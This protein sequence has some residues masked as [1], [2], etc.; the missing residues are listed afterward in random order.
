M[1]ADFQTDTEDATLP[2]AVDLRFPGEPL[3]FA[4][5]GIAGKMAAFPPFEFFRLTSHLQVNKAYIRDLNRSWYHSGLE[6]ITQD[7]AGTVDYLEGIVSES[8]TD[9]L[10]V[11]GSSMG[12]YAALLF[13]ALLRAQATHSFSPHTSLTNRRNVRNREE[14][15]SVHARY[16]S[17][18]FDLNDFLA[19]GEAPGDVHVYY[20]RTNRKD[21]KHITHLDDTFNVQFH[22]F[23]G[24][25]HNL[26]KYLK[27]AGELT[28]VVEASLDGVPYTPRTDIRL[29]RSLLDRVLGRKVR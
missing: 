29:R 17:R 11:F 15:K 3:L 5:G 27:A 23:K 20:D 6:G 4:F 22:P 10:V 28:K 9:R 21:R 2:I 19:P 18:Y 13:G 7:I 25:G 16:S 14:L 26:V 24:G 1:A 8:E 12:G